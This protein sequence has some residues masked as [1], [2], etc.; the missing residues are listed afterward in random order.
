M[1]KKTLLLILLSYYAATLFS[2]E[3]EKEIRKTALTFIDSLTPL[4]KKRALL[5]FSDSARTQWNNLPV[6]LRP[7]AG[8]NMGSLSDNQRIL[9]HRILSASLS[10]QGYL[11]ATSIMH[12]DNLLNMY[13]D[14]MY[15]RKEMNEKTH[16]FMI[17]LKWS[18][19]NFYLAFFGNPQTDTSWGYK[20]EGHHLSLNFTFHQNKLSITPMFVGTDPAEYPILEYA[21]WRVLGKEEDL[22]L[23]LINMMSPAQKKKATL[24]TEV[25]GDIITSAESGKRLVDYQGIKGSELNIQQ[26]EIVKQMIREFVF[27]LSYEKAVVEYDKI[28]KAGIGNLYFSWI[29]AYEEKQAHYYILNGPTFLIEFDNN[30]GPR[31]VANHIHAIWREKG[32]EYGEDVLKKHYIAEHQKQ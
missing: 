23:K 3:Y 20:L 8:I 1:F 27:N 12:L 6:G 26:L 15:Q 24:S 5:E 14:T 7:R 13:V 30:G 2:Q 29:G 4:Q 11:K 17:D 31:R 25:P 16:Q 10:S 28:V 32:N 19:Q 18:H 21:G 22:G 9:V